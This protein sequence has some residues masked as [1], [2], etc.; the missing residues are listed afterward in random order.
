MV[1]AT[2][3]VAGCHKANPAASRISIKHGLDPDASQINLNP[4]ETTL[5]ALANES[6]PAEYKGSLE[7]YPDQRVGSFEKQVWQVKATIK[8]VQLKPDG[9]Y[10]LVLQD[11]DGNE[12]VVEVPNPNLCK[13]SPL[14]S[15]IEQTRQYLQQNFHPT[16]K[17]QDVNQEATING[18]G[19]LG[20]RGRSKGGRLMP[21][22]NVQLGGKG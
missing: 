7:D 13:G 19:F 22:T 3:L 15:R 21:G 2:I 1:L 11:K 17:V 5:T 20:W 12:G 6:M 4:K 18:V 16:D 9:D 14:E 8:S 10:Y